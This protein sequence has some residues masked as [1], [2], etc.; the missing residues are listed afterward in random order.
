MEPQFVIDVV[1]LVAIYDLTKSGI[2]CLFNAWINSV[3]NSV[4][5]DDLYEENN[6]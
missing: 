3:T 1:I 5:L 4:D 2:K 6:K